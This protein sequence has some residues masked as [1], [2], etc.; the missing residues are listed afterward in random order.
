MSPVLFV[1][2]VLALRHRPELFTFK[3]KQAEYAET[4]M[5]SINRDSEPK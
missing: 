1:S 4:V 5:F 3:I 2:F